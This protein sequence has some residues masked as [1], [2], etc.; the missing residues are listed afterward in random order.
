MSGYCVFS[1]TFSNVGVGSTGFVVA[2][3][4]TAAKSSDSGISSNSLMEGSQSNTPSFLS[5]VPI[6]DR[7]GQFPFSKQLDFLHSL[8]LS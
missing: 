4:T 2:Y 5:A 1:F 7:S 6:A 8:I 3:H